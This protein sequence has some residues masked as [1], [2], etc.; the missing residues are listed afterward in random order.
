MLSPRDPQAF[1]ALMLRR[2]AQIERRRRRARLLLVVPSI[3]AVVL[4]AVLMFGSVPPGDVVVG[5][6]PTGENP[7]LQLAP[8]VLASRSWDLGGGRPWSVVG[9]HGGEMWVLGRDADNT[10]VVWMLDG[11]DVSVAARLPETAS[12]TVLAAGTDGRLWATD[13]AR[14]LVLRIDPAGGVD[15]FA[16]EAVPSPS[17]VFGPDGRFWFAEP[18][19][20][21]LTGMAPDGT[22]V[23]HELPAGRR[24]SVV[25]LGPEGGL[26]YASAASPRVGSVSSSGAVTEYDLPS[27]D[28]RVIAMAPGPGPALWLSI[29][30]L[31]GGV[32]ARMG[33][34][35]ELITEPL[36]QGRAPSAMS[37]GPDGRLWFS[38]GERSVITTRSLA[39]LERRSV[40]RSFEAD[41]WALATDGSM[42]A[43]D[44]T[45]GVLVQ[46]L[47]D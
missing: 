35:G 39:R 2:V 7:P 24:P 25:A 34:R 15:A 8:E 5:G 10:P 12:P 41:A 16:T 19:L 42:W 18:D 22:A 29:D 32:L 9:G 31:D 30:T 36:D 13:P 4:A 3:V 11:D 45:R 1:N 44:R 21:R 28:A 6:P 47:A 40:D 38:T 17:A 26:W 23:H 14:S 46:V 27:V 20:D 37:M 33:G 43:V